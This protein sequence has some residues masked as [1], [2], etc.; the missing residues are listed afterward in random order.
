M[1]FFKTEGERTDAKCV[2]YGSTTTH[3]GVDIERAEIK[4]GHKFQRKSTGGV[5]DLDITR[6]QA[7][8]V[9]LQ[10]LT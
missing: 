5:T 4:R 10:I 9:P 2:F 6:V 3:E 8:R 7:T 1:T